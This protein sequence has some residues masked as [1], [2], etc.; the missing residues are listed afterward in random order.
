MPALAA[1]KPTAC[2]TGLPRIFAKPISSDPL[3]PEVAQEPGPPRSKGHFVW[4]VPNRAQPPFFVRI[5]LTT[6]GKQI[7]VS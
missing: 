5:A 1:L 2:A 6:H 3:A 4:A 7:A